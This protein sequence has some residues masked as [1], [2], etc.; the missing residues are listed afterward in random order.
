PK[1]DKD[2]KVLKENILILENKLSEVISLL[3]FEND[4]N[5][6]ALL[7]NKYLELLKQLKELRNQ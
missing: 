1:V 6:K 4:L 2:E 7:E 5:K 3:S